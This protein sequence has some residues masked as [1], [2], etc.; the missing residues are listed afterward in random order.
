MTRNTI[1][2]LIGTKGSGK[3]FIGTLMEKEFGV[4]FIRVEDW[5]KA[6]KNNREVDDESYIREVFEVIEKGIRDSALQ[7]P[8]LVFESTGITPYFDKMLKSLQRDFKVITIKVMADDSL[9]L[10]RVKT[11]DQSIHIN[12]SDDQ[13]IAINDRVR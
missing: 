4:K 7:Y 10:H 5:A 2:L 11:R 6:V 12:V 13:V 3:S 9:C 8:K 1:Y